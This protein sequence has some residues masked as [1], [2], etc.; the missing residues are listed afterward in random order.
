MGTT[1]MI[2]QIGHDWYDTT[3]MT[4][5]VAVSQWLVQAGCFHMLACGPADGVNC[6]CNSKRI[7]YFMQCSEH[8][9][10][11]ALCNGAAPWPRTLVE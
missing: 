8:Q 6:C 4:A 5:A 2:R 1:G 7:C 3:T 9:S 11:E 10:L